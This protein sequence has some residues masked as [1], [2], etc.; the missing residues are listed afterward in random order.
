M[1]LKS[2]VGQQM[3]GPAVRQKEPV[4]VRSVLMTEGTF[5]PEEVHKLERAIAGQQASEVRSTLA[6]LNS[7]I[8]AGDA[9]D[10]DLTAA[11]VTAYLLGRHEL[12]DSFLRR[13]KKAG[14]ASFYHGEVLVALRRYADAEAAYAKA[15]EGGFDPVLCV[16]RRAGAIRLS[17][18]LDDADQLLTKHA[19]EAATRAEYSYQKGCLLADRGDTF[20]AI[21]YFE[22]AVDMDP[23]HTG[24][25]FRLAGLNDLLGNDD[26]AIRLYEQSLST[27]PLFLGALLNLG[28]LYEDKENYA[29][30]AYCFRRVLEVYP[31][32]ERAR[33]F[34]KDIEAAGDMYYDEEAARQQREL[35]HVM[36]ISVADF[37]LSARARNCLE[38][39]N[40]VTLGDLTRISESELLAGKNFGETSLTEIREMMASKGLRIG[41]MLR[42]E[43]FPAP[44]A[45]VFVQEDIA[46]EQRAVLERPVADLNLSVRSRKC[47][48]RLGINTLGELVSR[49]PDELLGVRNFGVTSLNEIRQKLADFDLRL[50]N[51]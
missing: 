8:E 5:G 11:G 21:E 49:T 42:M 22:R 25:M 16:L 19:R 9:S 33:L 46:P 38:R 47:L 2:H 39:A 37:E 32:H 12:A 15:A 43:P 24:A 18:R 40:I 30:A 13:V 7:R 23:H 3:G 44:K 45:P 20:G 48:S 50:R 26:E 29:A 10:R 31:N 4:D 51:D 1:A 6:E 35:E 36:R 41:Q 17:G 27:P 34:L 28:I 14:M